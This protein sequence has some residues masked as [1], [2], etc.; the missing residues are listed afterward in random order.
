M[1]LDASHDEEI[2]TFQDFLKT[3]GLKLTSQRNI[4]ARKVFG[5]TRH[6]SAEDLLDELRRE[7]RPISK[8]TVYRTLSLLEASTLVDSIAYQRGNKLYAHAPAG[9]GARGQRV[10]C[11]ACFKA[12]E[13]A[14]PALDALHESVARRH[15]FRAVAHAYRIYGV[16]DACAARGEGQ[17]DGAGAPSPASAR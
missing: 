2:A 14:E 10:V 11:V 12:V 3:R 9:G 5:T 13:F 1:P 8:A 4:L 6:F 7:K 17:A 16:C 15:G